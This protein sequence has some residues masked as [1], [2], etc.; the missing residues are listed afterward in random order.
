MDVH[1]CSN[2]QFNDI[3]L[4]SFLQIHGSIL[5]VNGNTASP[6]AGSND[7]RGTRKPGRHLMFAP[8]GPS[9][10]QLARKYIN[11]AR[12]RIPSF[13]FPHFLDGMTFGRADLVYVPMSSELSGFLTYRCRLLVW[14]LP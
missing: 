6:G 7:I 13:R 9:A 5:N 4:L 8:W 3:Y 14:D 1:G 10:M 2:F 11:E 12:S